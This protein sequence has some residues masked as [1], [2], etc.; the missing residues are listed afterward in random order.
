LRPKFSAYPLPRLPVP[1]FIF[2]LVAPL[3]GYSRD[4]VSLNMGYSMA[5]DSR[6]SRADLK[7]NYRDVRTSLCEHFQQLIDDGLLPNRLR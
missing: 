6:R 2:W 4:F 1:S 3:Y 7:L 5:F